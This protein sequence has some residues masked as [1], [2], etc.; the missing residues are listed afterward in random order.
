MYSPE[1]ILPRFVADLTLSPEHDFIK[2]YNTPHNWLT[3]FSYF[4]MVDLDVY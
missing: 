3:V 2:K 1:H 4:Y